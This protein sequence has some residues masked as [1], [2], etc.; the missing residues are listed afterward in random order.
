[1]GA[2]KIENPLMVAMIKIA[3]MMIVSFFWLL[4]CLP[5]VTI[6]PATA[7]LYHTTVKVIRKTAR[8]S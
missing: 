5:V 1:M 6:I 3:N 8:R 7:A 4:C 2:F